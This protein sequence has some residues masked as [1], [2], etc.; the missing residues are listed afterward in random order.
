MKKFLVIFLVLFASIF[1][2]NAERKEVIIDDNISIIYNDSLDGYWSEDFVDGRYVEDVMELDWVDSKNRIFGSNIPQY[3]ENVKDE[4][5]ERGNT[6]EFAKKRKNLLNKAF[7]FAR[8][9]SWS[10]ICFEEKESAIFF[11]YTGDDIYYFWA[12]GFD[13]E[14]E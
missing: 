9:Y 11:Y 5:L 6:E 1:S 3:L 12:G 14:E 2:L 10:I 13:I 8:K 4:L 7:A